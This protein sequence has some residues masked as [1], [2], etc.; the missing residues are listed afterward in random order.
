MTDKEMKQINMGFL[1]SP[2]PN[3]QPPPAT[4]PPRTAGCLFGSTYQA[5]RIIAN[6]NVQ[7]KNTITDMHLKNQQLPVEQ[8][9][10]LVD[11]IT[12]QQADFKS[13]LPVHVNTI[14]SRV[15]QNC[16]HVTQTSQVS[17]AIG[18]DARLIKI[19]HEYY[20]MNLELTRTEII[21]FANSHLHVP[22]WNS[23]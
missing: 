18:L 22:S 7:M 11:I 15:E 4:L 13:D 21:A 3:K 17:P 6:N 5:K 9:K 8:K 12:E 20:E 16:T 10:K 1:P 19:I 23:T 2:P 14:Y